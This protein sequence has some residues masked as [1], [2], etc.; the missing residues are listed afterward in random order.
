MAWRAARSYSEVGHKIWMERLREAKASAAEWFD[1]KPV[2]Q[3]ARAY[4]DKSSKCDHITS[5]FC[6]AFNACILELRFMPIAK[7]VQKY[8]LLMMRIFYDRELVGN[9]MNDGGVVPRVMI[10]INKHLYFTHEFTKQPSSDFV[11]TIL[12]TKKDISWNVYLK[13]HTCTCNVWQVSGIPCVHA[14]CASLHFRT[15]NF[16]QYVH[17]YMKVTNYRDL[18]APSLKPLRD[19]ALWAH[20]LLDDVKPPKVTRPTGRPRN[21]R[22]RDNDEIR[23]RNSRQYMCGKC[24]TYGHN[25]K[26]CTGAT[27]ANVDQAPA[28][29]T[30]PHVLNPTGRGV[31]GVQRG[32]VGSRGGGVSARRGRAFLRGGAVF[33]TSGRGNMHRIMDWLGT[34]EQWANDE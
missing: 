25:R 23:G 34:P 27:A 12:D 8:H 9:R 22:R 13:E 7:L 2:E 29:F 3:W 6:E 11:W 1:D 16:D 10:T 21:Q 33:S 4:F 31:G 20:N 32:C 24:Y 5:N 30:G 15:R 28:T 26:T 14:I 18:Y 19:K 17:P